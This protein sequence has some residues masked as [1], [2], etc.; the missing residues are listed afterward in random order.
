MLLTIINTMTAKNPITSSGV[1]SDELC[2]SLCAAAR[3]KSQELGVEISFAIADPSGLPRVFRRF[4]DALVL[5]ATLVPGKA[6]TSAV[7]QC[8]TKDVAKYAAEGQSLMAI[9]TNDPR[10]L[11]LPEAILSLPMERLSVPSELAEE[12]NRRIVK[13][14]NMLFLFLISIL[15]NNTNGIQV[16]SW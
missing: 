4:G 13:L 3:E 1:L 9:Q 16:E 7:T 15:E 2:D 6:Y 12:Q 5:S 8:T 10:I 14:P 11:S